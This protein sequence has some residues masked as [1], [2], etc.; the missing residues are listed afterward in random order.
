MK[1]LSVVG[2]RPQFIKLAPIVRAFESSG[3]SA[4]HLVVHTGQHY[5]YEMS[6]VFFESLGLPQPD[7]HLEIGSADHGAQTGRMLEA[8]EKVLLD[9]RPD[10]VV[11]YGDTNSTL[12]GALA[13]SK[14]HIRV[15]HVEAGL[16]SFNRLMPEEINRVVT[17]HVA[18]ILF[19]PSK[20]AVDHLGREGIDNVVEAGRVG[21]TSNFPVVYSV[22]DVMYDALLLSLQVAEERSDALDQFDVEPGSFYLATIHRAENVDRSDRMKAIF[23]ALRELSADSKVVLPIHPRTR[24][25]IDR[26]RNGLGALVWDLEVSVPLDYFDMLWLAKHA[27]A[28][29]T[30]SGGV[31][32]EAY[33]L[34]VPC[35]TLRD[36]TE[37]TETV[38]AGANVVVGAERERIVN[39]ATTTR[40]MSGD[41]TIY[42][43]GNAAVR[44][45]GLL[46]DLAG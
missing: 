27:K 36:E 37:W 14:L 19:C 10:M 2:A 13:A 21:G 7:H 40:S 45:V 1:V 32:K 31:Q 33:W 18:D 16:R 24:K 12:A 5:D 22:G 17:D 25:A 9:E 44:I 42:G 23:E 30:D 8:V 26:D 38:D 46:A 3:W 35:V 34:G 20:T 6:E 28:I 11:V 43:D 15:A 41:R 39:A 29:I 4:D